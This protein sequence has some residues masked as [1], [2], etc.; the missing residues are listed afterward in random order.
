VTACDYRY[1]AYEN[2]PDWPFITAERTDGFS[3]AAT[4]TCNPYTFKNDITRDQCFDLNGEPPAEGPQRCGDP[5]F[6][7]VRLSEDWQFFRVPFTELRQEGYGKEFPAIDL[8]AITMVRFTWIRRATTLAHR[9][10]NWSDS[11]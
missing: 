10:S 8:S 6:S 11:R 1:A 9:W 3:R 2:E 4:A 7:P 5:W